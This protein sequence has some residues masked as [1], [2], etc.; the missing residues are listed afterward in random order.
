MAPY[1]DEWDEHLILIVAA[2]PAAGILQQQFAR[3]GWRCVSSG[4]CSE[5][6][7]SLQVHNPAA[8]LTQDVLPDGTWREVFQSA[9]A[10]RP[11]AIRVVCSGQSTLHLWMDVFAHGGC[12]LVPEPCPDELLERILR[13]CGPRKAQACDPA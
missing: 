12:D 3:H 11:E 9:M 8:V 13:R 4:L 6:V 1:E 2:Q 7:A 10:I 5:A